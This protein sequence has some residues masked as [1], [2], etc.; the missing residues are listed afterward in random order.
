[1]A[2]SLLQNTTRLERKLEFFYFSIACIC[3][4]YLSS[5]YASAP[6]GLFFLVLGVA[7]SYANR[8]TALIML[9]GGTMLSY[10]YAIPIT[11]GFAILLLFL[12]LTLPLIFRSVYEMPFVFVVLVAL[13]FMMCAVSYSFHRSLDVVFV[14]FG[15]LAM[16]Q[17][18]SLVKF[19]RVSSSELFE[20]FGIAFFT[21]LAIPL[22]SNVFLN[23]DSPFFHERHL[24]QLKN[25]RYTVGTLEPNIV[26]AWM[27]CAFAIVVFSA[28]FKN[29]S[30]VYRIVYVFIASFLLYGTNSVGSRAAFVAVAIVIVLSLAFSFLFHQREKIKSICV[31]SVGIMTAGVIVAGFAWVVVSLITFEILPI[32]LERILQT[33]TLEETGRPYSLR[34]AEST[35]DKIPLT[36][37]HSKDYILHSAPL[38]PHNSFAASLLYLG[39]LVCIPYFLLLSIPVCDLLTK[40]RLSTD[41][42]WGFVITFFIF[43]TLTIPMTSNRTL[44]VVL[45]AW[46]AYSNLPPLKQASR[47]PAVSSVSS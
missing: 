34:L 10:V 41:W 43:I 36:G 31:K 19:T 14:C 39:L 23:I 8:K 3:L 47:L 5:I 37:I 26:A 12:P 24:W 20:L 42:R 45:G 27:A 40:F 32:S 29:K 15:V 9:F 1:M 33:T 4:L 17:S 22:L 30:L 7:I 46:F 28:K 16:L 18:Y 2:K 38:S 25:I 13:T 44:F 35:L 6:L 21:T 11:A